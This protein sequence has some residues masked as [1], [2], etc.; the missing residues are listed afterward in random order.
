VVLTIRGKSWGAP[1]LAVATAIQRGAK[2]P[3]FLLRFA[4]ALW[5]DCD[6][7]GIRA[8]VAWAQADL[9]TGHPDT[10]IG[11]VS[12]RYVEE[13]NTAGF[14]I[15]PDTPADEPGAGFGPE[16]WARIHA[17]HL[18]GYAGIT[19]PEAWRR[20]DFRWEPMLDAGYFG[21]ATTVHDLDGRWATSPDYGRKITERWAIYFTDEKQETEMQVVFEKRI[22][23]RRLA[24]HTARLANLD[25][26]FTIHENGNTAGRPYGEAAFV[27]N[28]GGGQGVLYHF[29]VGVEAG[30]PIIVQIFPL[31]RRGIHAGNA[32]GN[33]TAI[34][35]E[36]CQAPPG[37]LSD[38][39][40][41]ALRELL[42][43][44]YT[45]DPRID[46]GAGG[47]RFAPD[48]TNMHANWRGANP[49]CPE[50][51]LR[52]WGGI[53]PVLSDVRGRLT[54]QPVPEPETIGVGDTVATIVT[55]NVRAAPGTDAAI[56]V[57]LMPGVDAVVTGRP[58]TADGYEWV[59]LRLGDGREGWAA[60]AGTDGTYLTVIVKAPVLPAEPDL[61]LGLPVP[62][63][64]SLFGA[65]DVD[66]TR[67]AFN[68]AGVVSRLWLDYAEETDRFPTL[69]SVF[70]EAGRKVFQFA[71]G[72]VI[73]APPDR[74]AEVER[75]IA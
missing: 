39:T 63:I 25:A 8:D 19:P 3:E 59:P 6:V 28:G 22:A 16:D 50:L 36:T 51:M 52:H 54:N 71:D 62:L 43:M 18:A 56:L 35:V 47:Y 10:G 40:Q 7:L 60:T 66:Q 32:T 5:A 4:V 72:L 65:V 57:T 26:W 24:S 73:T 42:H 75:L 48:R 12:R 13:G 55:L 2:R 15:T 20:L 27:N 38:M 45:G 70:T 69:S 23:T 44:V 1:E 49:N 46:W 29:A 58:E 11:F 14:G 74:P 41:A 9:E 21:V 68:P 67:Y 53:Q 30:R 37:A 17:I 64:S 61:I 31:D 34:A 33:Q